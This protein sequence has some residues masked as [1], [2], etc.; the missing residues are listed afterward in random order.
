LVSEQGSH[1]PLRVK[2]GVISTASSACFARSPCCPVAIQT[3]SSAVFFKLRKTGASFKIS[4]RVPA[5]IAI[6]IIAPQ[7]DW[8]ASPPEI[9]RTG[10][11]AL[12]QG[13]ITT[14]KRR[15]RDRKDK[16][17]PIGAVKCL[18][19]PMQAIRRQFYSSCIRNSTF[20]S[21]ASQTMAAQAAIF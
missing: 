15:F 4:G 19:R 16:T 6:P 10:K 20:E 8:R 9:S 2:A 3:G 5:I 1:P 18:L 12:N 21:A 7:C 17:A 14:A 11:V 13:V